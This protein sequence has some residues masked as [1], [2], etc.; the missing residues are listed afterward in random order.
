MRLDFILLVLDFVFLLRL[1]LPP[2]DSLPDDELPED[3]PEALLTLESLPLALLN[4]SSLELYNMS[5]FCYQPYS[6]IVVYYS[7]SFK[8]QL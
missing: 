8:F 6:N 5:K 2:E 4:S 1:D 7:C 3:V